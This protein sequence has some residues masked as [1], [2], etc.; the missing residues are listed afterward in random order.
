[1]SETC[2]T[3]RKKFDSG[4]WMSPQFKDERV[5]LFCS[6]KCKNQY[7]KMKLERIKV[8]YPKYYDKIMKSSKK[9]GIYNFNLKEADKH[10]WWI[11]QDSNLGKKH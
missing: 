8:N 1:M 2:K 7:L 6:N 11:K 4:I 3:C 9:K 10:E 5:L